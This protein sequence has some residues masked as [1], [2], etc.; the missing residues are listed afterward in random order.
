MIGPNTTIERLLRPW[1]AGLAPL[2]VGGMLIAACGPVSPAGSGTPPTTTT[3]T[4]VA[5]ATKTKF[6]I[7]PSAATKALVVGGT[8]GGRSN[9]YLVDVHARKILGTIGFGYADSDPAIALSAGATAAYVCTRDPAM[10]FQT[11]TIRLDLSNFT[12]APPIPLGPKT[13]NLG[14]AGIAVTSPGHLLAEVGNSLIEVL[15]G[16]TSHQVVA[17][18][19]GTQAGR[20]S[21]DGPA[22]TAYIPRQV[23]IRLELIPF[24]TSSNTL[25][26][27]IILSSL[28][29]SEMTG[30]VFPGH[31]KAWALVT[32]SG[33]ISGSWIVPVLTA[34]H[35]AGNPITLPPA[36]IP[37]GLTGSGGS[38]YL[39]AF[40]G[41][42]QGPAIYSIQP[43]G[44]T[45]QELLKLPATWAVDLKAA[46][47]SL[48]VTMGTSSASAAIALLDP[49]APSGLTLLPVP[50][51]AQA[52][53][54][55][56]AVPG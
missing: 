25:G 5:A 53:P 1:R 37:T 3:T 16:G 18:L 21:F 8:A 33:S 19:P 31:G 29:P 6:P 22:A 4:G 26:T 12:A 51:A 23:G 52:G 34:A 14:C 28:A 15:K 24:N 43:A 49:V 35:R 39:L 40:P 41:P 36:L 56:I 54:G 7:P 55:P 48:V 47:G 13:F 38:L 30:I 10:G 9:A 46:A 50:M 11:V 2:A 45:P 32:R 44:S 20:M 17:R 42:L 27:P